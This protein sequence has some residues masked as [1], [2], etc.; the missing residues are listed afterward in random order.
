MKPWPSPDT[1]AII[2]ARLGDPH[3][4]RAPGDRPEFCWQCEHVVM[5][6]L[7]TLNRAKTLPASRIICIP[8]AA[9]YADRSGRKIRVIP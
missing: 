6:R 2:C 8:C 5:I 9:A 4:V 7:E 1:V 3:R